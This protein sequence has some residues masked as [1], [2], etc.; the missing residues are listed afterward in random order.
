MGIETMDSCEDVLLTLFC[1][2]ADEERCRCSRVPFKVCDMFATGFTYTRNEFIRQPLL[3]PLSRSVFMS[4]YVAWH[5]MGSPLLFARLFAHF[6]LQCWMSATT[7]T[8][9]E[10]V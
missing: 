1:F 6:C 8:D 5:Y 2:V 10:G 4:P 3:A 7:P 9:L